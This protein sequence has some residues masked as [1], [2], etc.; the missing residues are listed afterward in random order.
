MNK[1]ITRV[2]L[3]V[4]LVPLIV[5]AACA[6]DQKVIMV[7]GDDGP[8]LGVRIENLSGKMLKNLNLENGI[9]VI[10]VLRDSPA[11]KAGIE[12]DDILISFDGKELSDSEDLVDLVNRWDVDETVTI[13]LLRDGQQRE[14]SVAMET[15]E[16][17]NVIRWHDKDW[18]SQSFQMEK[19][20]WLGVESE[21]LNDQLREFFGVD[22]DLGVLVK[23]V[24][25]DSPADQS[26]I[27]AGDVVIKVADRDIKNTRDLVRSI[28]YY[29]PEEVVPVTVIREK[30]AKSFKVKL[31][32][33]DDFRNFKFYGISPDMID[34]P[35]MDIT[36]P[37]VP[38]IDVQIDTKELDE[39]KENMEELKKDIKLK[40]IQ[41]RKRGDEV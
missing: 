34:M 26:G 15:R 30:K 28:N 33:T 11:E 13:G 14:V 24:I 4:I 17:K 9:R 10:K 41:I 27:K 18:Q 35:E 38:D 1:L 3:L 36:V 16:N 2:S 39:L 20:A 12:E 5:M 8:W 31:G 22:A 23:K 7:A 19:R 37:E 29:D 32:E 6:D 25:K 21:N 40:K